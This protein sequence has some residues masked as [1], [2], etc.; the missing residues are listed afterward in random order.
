VLRDFFFINQ[1]YRRATVIQIAPLEISKDIS[2][3]GMTPGV[4]NTVMTT[5]M[6]LVMTVTMEHEYEDVLDN[7]DDDNDSVDKK[8]IPQ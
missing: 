7:E 6:L 3:S 2:N 1:L 5:Q 8:V 4:K